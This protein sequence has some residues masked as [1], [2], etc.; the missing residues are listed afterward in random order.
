MSFF[1]KLFNMT[2]SKNT[3]TAH[4]EPIYINEKLLIDHHL[5]DSELACFRTF[6][7]VHKNYLVHP[8]T[9]ED[10]Q[11]LEYMKEFLP[12]IC[13]LWSDEYGNYAGFF[14]R[15]ALRG[16]IMILTH[17]ETLYAPLYSSMKSFIAAVMDSSFEELMIPRLFPTD[18]SESYMADYP[19]KTPTVKEQQEN[20]TAAKQLLS[21]LDSMSDEES[22]A[23]T[24]FQIF[25]IMPHEHLD[26]L[27]VFFDSDNLYILQDIPY[28]FAFHHYQPA[29]AYLKEAVQ[30]NTPHISSHAK[31]ALTYYTITD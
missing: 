11:A 7:Q 15:G 25:Y 3:N 13:F 2:D 20:Y 22:Y 8:I 12:D 26:E 29:V 5:S 17:S 18:L 1:K 30:K 23:Q 6:K 19:A 16:K 21:T 14:Y 10:Y 4:S 24:V 9:Q 28:L 31:R 27:L